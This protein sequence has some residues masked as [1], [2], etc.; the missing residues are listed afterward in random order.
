[1][2]LCGKDIRLQA[3]VYSN[4]TNVIAPINISMVCC[5]LSFMLLW[6]YFYVG[7]IVPFRL[8]W[9]RTGCTVPSL[10]VTVGGDGVRTMR[11]SC[12]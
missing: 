10:V 9:L 11:P 8:P 4:K 5:L 12:G 7:Y 6:C 2:A 3:V 1:M